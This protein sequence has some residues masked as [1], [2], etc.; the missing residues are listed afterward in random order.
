MGGTTIIT[1]SG[2]GWPVSSVN[3]KREAARAKS[4]PEMF[5]IMLAAEGGRRGSCSATPHKRDKTEDNGQR[6]H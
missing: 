3:V 5:G 4:A 2:C 1:G 6:G